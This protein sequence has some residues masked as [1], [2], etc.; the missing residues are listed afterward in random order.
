MAKLARRGEAD[1]PEVGRDAGAS[2]EPARILE[3]SDREQMRPAG[4][5]GLFTFPL[6]VLA[7]VN[8]VDHVD[9]AIL[10]GVLP[11]IGEEFQASDRALGLLGFA[12][13]FVNILASIPA[14]WM[15]DNFRRGRVIGYTLASWSLLSALSAA[16]FNYWS[17]LVARGVMGFGQAIDD[18]ASTSLIGD[19]FPPH[20]RGRVFSVQQVMVFAGSAVG[21]ALAGLVGSVLGWRWAFLLVGTPGSLVALMAFRLR[22]PQRGEADRA[23]LGLGDS[24]DHGGAEGV[25]RRIGRTE[26]LS[27]FLKEASVDL[28][29]QI[30]ALLRIRTMRYILTGA[31]TLLFTVQGIGY[32]LAVFHQRYSGMSLAQ[33]TAVTAG[34]L[35][36]AGVV[37]TFWGGAL[38]DRLLAR[39]GYIARI[40]LSVAMILVGSLAFLASWV[41][42][43]VPVR[44]GLQFVGM[45]VISTVPPT[46]RASA[47][48]VVPANSRGVGTSAFAVVTALFGTALAPAVVGWLSDLTDLRRAFLLVSPP[49]AAGTLILWRARFTI[50]DD[51]QKMLEMLVAQETEGR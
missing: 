10:R 32:W 31:A 26:K 29:R 17:L 8:F 15:A 2:G 16:A 30:V 18:P 34:T 20:M 43:I 47:L 49:I 7:L 12:F 14:G 40:D 39:K 23:A 45:L 35:G 27:T 33:A 46:L 9:L 44:L 19:Y 24:A 25:S 4:R 48:D 50:V 28:Y 42:E 1:L 37:G 11:L 38:A 22:E 3:Q 51:A 36:L 21:L 5:R 13:I 6:V 41:V